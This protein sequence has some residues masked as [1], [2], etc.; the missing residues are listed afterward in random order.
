MCD[1]LSPQ[2]AANSDSATAVQSTTWHRALPTARGVNR[3]C[4]VSDVAAAYRADRSTALPARAPGPRHFRTARGCLRYQS[5]RIRRAS[6]DQ[7]PAACFSRGIRTGDLLIPFTCSVQLWAAAAE[8]GPGGRALPVH[9]C[10]R[11]QYADTRR[12]EHHQQPARHA[13]QR[14]DGAF[15]APSALRLAEGRSHTVR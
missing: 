11:R 5:G 12:D 4:R 15:G 2:R 6:H 7:R 13:T 9:D 3:S 10:W 1:R 14:I 8:S